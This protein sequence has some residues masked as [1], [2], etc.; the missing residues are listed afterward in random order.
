[1]KEKK[2]ESGTT[3]CWS[4]SLTLDF[5]KRLIYVTYAEEKVESYVIRLK[6][7]VPI[8]KNNITKLNNFLLALN[9]FSSFVPESFL[10]PNYYLDNLSDISIC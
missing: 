1:M 5:S 2:K 10:A 4:V 9:N 6:T 3:F 7:K 8:F